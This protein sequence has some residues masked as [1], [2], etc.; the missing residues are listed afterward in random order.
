MSRTPKN[1]EPLSVETLIQGKT[2]LSMAVDAIDEAIAICDA[3]G[4][5]SIE[6]EYIASLARALKP[7]GTFTDSLRYATALK[8]A[9]DNRT[10]LFDK[11]DDLAAKGKRSGAGKTK[12]G[13]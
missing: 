9:N 8:R 3:S 7:L 11:I 4:E 12:K 5:D 13:G 2:R 6:C 1:F 10:D